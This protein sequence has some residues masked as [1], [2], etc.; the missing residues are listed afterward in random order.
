MK[1]L[2]HEMIP[3]ILNLCST[4]TAPLSDNTPGIMFFK[5]IQDTHPSTCPRQTVVQAQTQ[6]V[7]PQ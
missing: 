1:G 3:G 6:R 5:V 2:T 7:M 4:Q